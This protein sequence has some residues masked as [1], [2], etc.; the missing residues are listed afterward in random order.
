MMYLKFENRKNGLAFK[1]TFNIP[2]TGDTSGADD[3]PGIAS[4]ITAPFEL[5]SGADD[6]TLTGNGSARTTET[7]ELLP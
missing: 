7:I 6:G 1:S 5:T 3:G 2:A 4:S